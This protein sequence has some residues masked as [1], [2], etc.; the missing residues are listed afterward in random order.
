[1]VEGDVIPAMT[2]DR[3]IEVLKEAKL[4]SKPIIKKPSCDCEEGFM[5]TGLGLMKPCTKCNK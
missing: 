3:F 5:Y 2:E 1:M 4:L